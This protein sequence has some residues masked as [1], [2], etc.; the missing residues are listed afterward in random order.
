MLR[1]RNIGAWNVMIEPQMIRRMSDLVFVAVVALCCAHAAQHAPRITTLA[2]AQAAPP[3]PNVCDAHSGET[4]YIERLGQVV[5]G[6]EFMD[7]V[8]MTCIP[9]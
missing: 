3:M 6:A 8:Q 4:G 1:A 9:R 7:A 5:T 2:P